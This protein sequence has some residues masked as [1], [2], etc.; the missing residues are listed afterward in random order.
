MPLGPKI[1]PTADD[2]RNAWKTL[3]QRAADGDPMSC[4]LVISL[5]N[6]SKTKQ[7]SYEMIDTKIAELNA[8]FQTA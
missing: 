7:S 1:K 6:P 2:V 4:A 5:A 8:S 3:K